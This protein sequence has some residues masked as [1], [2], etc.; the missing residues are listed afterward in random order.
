MGEQVLEDVEFSR[1]VIP[2]KVLGA[3]SSTE[4]TDSLVSRFSIG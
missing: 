1:I 2:T 3:F 4:G